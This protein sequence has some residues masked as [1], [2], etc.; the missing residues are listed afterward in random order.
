MGYYIPK[1]A[2]PE[3]NYRMSSESKKGAVP[4]VLN[5]LLGQPKEGEKPLK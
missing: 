1:L 4:K 2:K 3:F 5:F